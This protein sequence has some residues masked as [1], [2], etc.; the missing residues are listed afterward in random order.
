M[1]GSQALE[2]A[3]GL[4]LLFFVLATAASAIAEAISRKLQKRS[5]DLEKA[6]MV[7]LETGDLTAETRG[8]TP[9][10]VQSLLQTAAGKAS[11][12]Y[13]SAKAF[14]DAATQLVSK[15][16]NIGFLRER[17]DGL[18][19]ET[20]ADLV[21]VKAGLENWFD[22]AMSQAQAQYKKW[23]AAIL[24]SIGLVLSVSLNAST[25][26]V[27]HDLWSGVV[28]R[29]AVVEA[30]GNAQESADACSKGTDIE[31]ASCAV[32]NVSSSQ[33]PLG[34]RDAQRD[35]AWNNGTDDAIFWWLSHVVGWLLTACLIMLGAPFWF[36]L[37][38]RLVNLRAGGRRPKQAPEDEGSS[39]YLMNITGMTDPRPSKYWVPT[40]EVVHQRAVARAPQRKYTD[41]TTWEPGDLDAAS[42]P[43]DVDWLATALNLGEPL[44][45]TTRS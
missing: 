2:T 21:G 9:R 16:Q 36:D 7:M 33:L 14:A 8:V 30:A 41:R 39:N 24:F 27:A 4:A 42:N 3:I 35:G 32:E 40:L 15:G 31:Q 18:A 19:R 34:W 1:F 38:G 45:R 25:L 37:V 44:D 26:N 17:M 23:A 28:V 6:I 43:R 5:T 29:E 22:E 20:R 11:A 12:T 13:L 10:E